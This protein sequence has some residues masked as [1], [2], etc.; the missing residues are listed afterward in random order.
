MA[1]RKKV[2]VALSGGGSKGIA[3]IGVLKALEKYNIPI[4]FVA[5]TSI[6]AVILI[7]F[8]IFSVYRLLFRHSP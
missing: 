8:H 2:G 4:D 3:H 1:K 5:G 7:V 6:G